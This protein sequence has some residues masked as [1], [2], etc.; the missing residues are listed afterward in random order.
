MHGC[1]DE[2]EILLRKCLYHRENDLVVFNG[3]IVNKGAKSVQVHLVC[4]HTTMADSSV[5]TGNAIQAK[6]AHAPISIPCHIF[7]NQPG[8][9]QVIDRIQSMDAVVVRGNQDDKALAA[10]VQWKHGKALVSA[11]D[12]LVSCTPLP[13][14]SAASLSLMWVLQYS[15]IHTSHYYLCLLPKLWG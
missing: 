15:G 4:T 7:H 10:Y 12:L 5:H 1:A 3:D 13:Q 9:L 11:S 6:L 8:L 2:L 14:H